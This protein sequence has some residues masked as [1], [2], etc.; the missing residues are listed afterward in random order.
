MYDAVFF[1]E[2]TDNINAAKPLGAYKCAHVLRTHGY[3]CL[4]VD[5]L[6]YFTS[7]ELVKLIDLAVSE[8]TTMVGFSSTFLANSNVGQNEDGSTPPFT[9]LLGET[10]L[11]QGQEVENRI[12]K[13]IRS[14]S[15]N[16]KIVLGGARVKPDYQTKNIDYA[17]VGYSEAS[18]LNLMNHLC[19]G[20]QLNHN[21][22]NIFGRMVIDDRKAESY[23]FANS[24]MAWEYTDIINQTVLPLEVARGC[25]FKC[26]FC[27]YPMNGKQNLDFIRHEKNIQYELERNYEEYG[28]KTYS[29]V[30]DTFNDND[31][32]LDALLR[33]IK[34]LKFQPDFWAYNRLDLLARKTETNI[35]KLYDIGLRG[36]QFGIETLNERTGQIIGKGYD[37]GKQ[38]EAIQKIRK[39]FGNEI[40]M[41]GGFIVGLPDESEESCR[42]TFERLMSGEIPLHSWRFNPLWIHK[43]NRFAWSSDIEANYKNYG[44]EEI[45][46]D[47]SS[48]FVKWRNK[49]TDFLRVEILAKEFNSKSEASDR[50]YVPNILGYGIR[51]L[52]FDHSYLTTTLHRDI[53]WGDIETRKTKFGLEYKEKLFAYLEKHQI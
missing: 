17:F 24:T 43:Y 22:K 52:G 16:A 5:N 4:V 25:I 15:A 27:S 44:Y 6:H 12:V 51:P 3:S 29:I 31:I 18:I 8:K 37:R 32:K 42:D 21:Y 46:D 50:F 26:K 38:I 41:H 53:N 39:K 14:H 1:T 19:K 11:P 13:E 10:F 28:I 40:A 49:H 23:D 34:K 7:D 33:S 35:Q 45:S 9:Y 2:I 30:D 36:T 48:V 47:P 20:E